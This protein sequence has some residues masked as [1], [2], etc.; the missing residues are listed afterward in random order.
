MKFGAKDY[1]KKDFLDY[2]ADKADFLEIQGLRSHNYDFIRKY[3]L[4]I[5]IHA[6]HH[7]Q[8]SNPADPNCMTNL[9]SIKNAQRIAKTVNAKK[10]VFHPGHIRD[11]NCSKENAINFIKKIDDNRILLENLGDEHSLCKKPEDMREFME[12]TGKA[13]IFDVAHAMINANRFKE[14][15]I[16]FIKKFLRLGPS[17]FHISGQMI[18][19]LNDQHLALHECNIDWYEILKLFPKD[20]EVTMEVSQ[21]IEKTDKDLKMI[22]NIAKKVC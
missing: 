4:P 14:N 13:F 20:A 8:G 9:E 16:D 11:Y 19:E 22:R 15:Q 12:E 21:D 2:F 6:E 7:N 1:Y 3:K 17:H 10:I 5:V 18:N